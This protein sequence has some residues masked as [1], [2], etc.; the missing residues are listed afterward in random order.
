MNKLRLTLFVLFLSLSAYCQFPTPGVEGFENTTGPDAPPATNWTLGTGATGNQWAVFDN[1]V[2]AAT[3]V[4]WSINATSY[5]GTNAA[6]MNRQ[7]VGNGSTS[8]DYLATPLVTVP[9]NGQL[10]FFSRT[11]VNGLTGTLYQIKIAPATALQTD[12]NA[13]S[14]VVQYNEDQL[15]FN[16]QTGVQNLFSTYTEKVV[17]L[18]AFA[19][20]QVY[21]AFVMKNTQ[22]GTAA[23]GDRW[24]LDDVSLVEQCLNPSGGTA[25]VLSTSASL[26][27]ASTGASSWEIEVV[28]GTGTPTGVGVVYNGALPYN[29]TGLTPNTN[30]CFYIKSLC[31]NSS[32]TWVGPFCFTTSIA[33]PVCGG[34]YVDSGGIGAN[35]PN[36]ADE[37]VTICPVT[38]G[39]VVTVTFT[40]FNTQA[41]ADGLYVFNGSVS[42]T[43]QII[44]GN[45]AGTVPGGV[46]GSYW[47]T[48][49]PGPF[50]SSSPDGCLTFRFRSGAGTNNTGWVANVTCGPP[51]SCP[52]PNGLTT[53]AVLSM[54]RGFQIVLQQPII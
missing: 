25:T 15:T 26:N 18:S 11:F 41:T 36:N 16:D 21:I 38:A 10:H 54:L 28:P 9:A 51:P 40:S 42:G 33:P 29:V 50:T 46:A 14:L 19:G 12:F 35:Y 30:Y 34:N 52:S 43:N 22:T 32:S 1:G 23:T 49:N 37:T 5:Q 13:Y 27:W 20:Q 48:A 3:N 47:G 45:P 39:E 17:P 7:N 2:S 31:P 44:S 4:N 24:L 6:Y 53:S 8:E